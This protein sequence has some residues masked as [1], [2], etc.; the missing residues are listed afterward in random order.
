MGGGEKINWGE[1][2]SIEIYSHFKLFMTLTEIKTYV[3]SKELIIHVVFWI[4]YFS[5]VN[6]S[7]T[8][9]WL[10][11]S[12]RLDNP[13]PI[14][15]LSFPIFFYL[16]AFWLIPTFLKR[17]NIF[18]Y[19]AVA[20]PIVC[21]AELFR[22]V[23]FVLFAP[24]STVFLN[25]LIDTF[26]GRESLIFGVPNSM[27]FA[28]LLSFAYRFSKDWVINTQ[29]IEQLKTEKIAMELNMLK[30]QI[31][32]HFLFNNLNALD[33]LIDRDQ[34]RA[35][36]YL[37]KLSNIYR[38]SITS[39][40][41]DVVSLQE[42]WAFADDYIYL[43]EER[44]DGIYQFEKINSLDRMSNYL[45]PPSSLQSL[46]EN[47]VKH[48]HGSREEPLVITIQADQNGIKVSHLKKLKNTDVNSLGTGLKNLKS[49]YKLLT[50]KEIDIRDDDSFTVILPLIE[51]VHA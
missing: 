49:R 26:L 42:E 27:F 23:I 32:P 4:F 3:S 44:F 36:D 17:K 24:N 14:S 39:I 29:I 40:D 51:E 13:S 31:N 5:S 41:L 43:I 30:A 1:L 46:I 8:E 15:G 25:T 22:S 37:H 38:Y 16:N 21:L 28:F 34:Q 48:N 6:I 7:W 12:L 19:L 9:N 2:I 18:R 11:G 20:L 50:N 35:K 33:D 45:I 47:A 10:D